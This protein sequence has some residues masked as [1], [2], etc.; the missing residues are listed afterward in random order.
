MKSS[1]MPEKPLL[2]YPSIA[3][4]LGLEESVMLS[5][6]SDLTCAKTP[7]IRNHYAWYRLDIEQLLDSMPFWNQRDLQRVST[8]LREKGI[9]IVASASLAQANEFKFSFNEKVMAAQKTPTAAR[10]Q[11][12]EQQTRAAPMQDV[13]QFLGKNF[14]SNH[15]QPDQDTLLQLAQHNIPEQFALQ[16]LPEFVTYWRERG[17]AH[18]SWGSKFINHTIR[19][20]RDFE[21]RRHQEQSEVTMHPNWHPSADALEIMTQQAEIPLTFIEDAIPEFILYWQERGDKLKTWNSKFIQHV[22]L[23]WKKFNSSIESSSDPRPISDNW[24]PSADVYDILQMANINLNFA[25]ELVPEFVLYWRDSNQVHTSWN[26]RY[27][28][29]VKRKWAGQHA[30]IKPS[31]INRSTRDMTLEEE[32]TDRSWAS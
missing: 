23:Q 21:S 32:L 1:L 18:H 12:A 10:A 26:T 8:N 31:E 7:E 2:I 9:I 25:R 19:K 6:L 28:Q 14:I 22:R 16:Q 30:Q 15:W 4:T 27:L 13:P 20:W 29:Y 3:A 24:Q 11:P 5:A 17:E